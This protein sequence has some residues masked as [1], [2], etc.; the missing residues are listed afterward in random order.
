MKKMLSRPSTGC[1]VI[2]MKETRFY[3]RMGDVSARTVALKLAKSRPGE[4]I[5]LESDEIRAYKDPTRFGTIITEYEI[6]KPHNSGE[7][8][9][10]FGC[11]CG[12]VI[13]SLMVRN[14]I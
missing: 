5:G 2:D 11:Q 4:I 3:Y 8:S 14:G 12:K 6:E 7:E 10:V 1:G 9:W 13:T